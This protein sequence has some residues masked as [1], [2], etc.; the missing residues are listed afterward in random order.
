MGSKKPLGLRI[1]SSFLKVSKK[2]FS[3]LSQN[4]SI[5][6]FVNFSASSYQ[7]VFSVEL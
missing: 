1:K 7:Y 5:V 6:E 2:T 4:L 3:F